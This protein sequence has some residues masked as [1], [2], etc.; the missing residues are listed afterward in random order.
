MN[1]HDRD[2]KKAAREEGIAEGKAQGLAEGKAQGLAEGAQQQAIETARRM[3]NKKFSA[4]DIS[5]MTGLPL[6]EVLKLQKE[7]K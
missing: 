5:E 6:E 2:I 3:L 1:L 7:I 4:D